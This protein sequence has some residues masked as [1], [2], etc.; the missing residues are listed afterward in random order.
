MYNS[1]KSHFRKTFSEF[2]D[3]ILYSTYKKDSKC[4]KLKRFFYDVFNMMIQ[5]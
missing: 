1:L 5:I 3:Q 4:N 2:I